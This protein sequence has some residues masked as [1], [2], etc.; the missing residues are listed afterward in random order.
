MGPAAPLPL[1]TH[2]ERGFYHEGDDSLLIQVKPIAR[3]EGQAYI[4][5]HAAKL[6]DQGYD[7][8]ELAMALDASLNAGPN[9]FRDTRLGAT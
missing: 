5:H 2:D 3:A 9:P 1:A 6:V 8:A 7:E 4:D